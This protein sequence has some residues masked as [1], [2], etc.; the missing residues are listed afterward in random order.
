[1]DS[2]ILGLRADEDVQLALDAFDTALTVLAA[3]EDVAARL[4][5]PPVEPV[6]RPVA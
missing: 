2:W 4:V 1:M 3:G 5:G 6:F